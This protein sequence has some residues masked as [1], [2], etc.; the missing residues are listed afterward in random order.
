MEIAYFPVCTLKT[1][2]VGF[3]DSV[4]DTARAFGYDL[5]EVPDWTCCGATF[6]LAH[7]FDQLLHG[8]VLIGVA[9][10]VLRPTG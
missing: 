6:N 10:L 4:V 2:A 9:W 7:G 8:L 5:V 1:K 3:D